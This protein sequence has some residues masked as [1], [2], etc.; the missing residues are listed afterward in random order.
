MSQNTSG[1]SEE[2]QCVSPLSIVAVVG[3]NT[4]AQ[5]VQ[6]LFERVSHLLKAPLCLDIYREDQA[7]A[8]LEG[9]LTDLLRSEHGKRMLILPWS[10]SPRTA[11]LI[12]AAKA[13]LG[14]TTHETV[15]EWCLSPLQYSASEVASFGSWDG[16][17]NPAQALDRLITTFPGWSRQGTLLHSGTCLVLL[18]CTDQMEQRACRAVVLS[19]MQAVG[20]VLLSD[21]AVSVP[22]HLDGV[23]TVSYF[24]RWMCDLVL[25]LT[26]TACTAT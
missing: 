24:T 23:I 21:D 8:P 18:P 3:E 10:V 5:L 2:T 7:S 26:A 15:E 6:A 22:L 11:S 25:T 9:Y 16:I 14:A 19:M 13:A 12:E 20:S 1:F 4:S 17:R